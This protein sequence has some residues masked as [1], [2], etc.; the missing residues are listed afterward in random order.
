MISIIEKI[1]HTEDEELDVLA[2]MIYKHAYLDRGIKETCISMIC[3][4]LRLKGKLGYQ[5]TACLALLK[6]LTSG[7]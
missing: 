1:D 5:H 3:K 4:R 2:R 6:D 7:Y